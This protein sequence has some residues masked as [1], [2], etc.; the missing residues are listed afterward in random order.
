MGWSE[1]GMVWSEVGMV[2]SEVDM[3]WSEVGMGW[4]EV[5]TERCGVEWGWGRVEV[6]RQTYSPESILT[7]A[8]DALYRAVS[9]NKG[10]WISAV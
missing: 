1:V 6:V 5:G 7:L 4:S 10:K 3:V 2:W 8:V 9:S